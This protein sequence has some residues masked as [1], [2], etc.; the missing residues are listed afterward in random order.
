MPYIPSK[1]PR[2]HDFLSDRINTQLALARGMSTDRTALGLGGRSRQHVS[3][4]L[5]KGIRLRA[6]DRPAFSPSN[7]RSA[8]MAR[9]LVHRRNLHRLCSG[10]RCQD[11]GERQAAPESRL[12][13]ACSALGEWRACCC[14][15]RRRQ[16]LTRETG[17]CARSHVHLISVTITRLSAQT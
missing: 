14:S 11:H 4:A 9:T 10:P 3:Y 15:C 13:R 5:R 8:R 2:I 1:F 6:L 16:N 12:G 17:E 7:R